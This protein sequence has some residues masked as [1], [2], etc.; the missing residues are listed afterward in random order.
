MNTNDMYTREKLARI[1]QEEIIRDARNA[2]EFPIDLKAALA[3]RKLWLT[4]GVLIALAALI[5]L[6]SA[7]GLHPPWSLL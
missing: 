3:N 7:A 5:A 6:A 1:R 2:R 4:L